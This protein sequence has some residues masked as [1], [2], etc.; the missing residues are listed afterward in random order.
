MLVV[1]QSKIPARPK[2]TDRLRVRI[3]WYHIPIV[4]AVFLFWFY[5][6]TLIT[7]LFIPLDVTF[8]LSQ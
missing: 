7:S 1:S 8:G 5:L 2:L 4:I 6:T 3:R